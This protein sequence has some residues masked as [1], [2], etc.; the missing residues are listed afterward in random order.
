M[1]KGLTFLAGI[2][3]VIGGFKIVEALG[4]IFLQIS[5]SAVFEYPEI[6]NSYPISGEDINLLRDVGVL[7]KTPFWNIFILLLGIAFLVLGIL[8]FVRRHRIKVAAAEKNLD[9]MVTSTYGMMIIFLVVFSVLLLLMGVE[10]FLIG[11]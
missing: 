6:L 3:C 11:W 9:Q 5:L 10:S 8:G 4:S 2:S 7:V 1:E